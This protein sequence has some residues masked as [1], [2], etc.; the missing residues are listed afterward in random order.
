MPAKKKKFVNY[1]LKHPEGLDVIPDHLREKI[2]LAIDF[3]DGTTDDW[4]KIKPVLVNLFPLSDRTR[5]SRRH[6]STKKQILNL[7]DKA[8]INYW[9]EATGVELWIDP[10]KL[11]D[12]SWKRNPVGWGLIAINKARIEN[13][14]NKQKKKDPKRVAKPAN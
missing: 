8:V 7:F 10:E 5:F 6:Y 9:K 14:K 3:I 1:K 11:H 4:F 2:D 13:A 12:M